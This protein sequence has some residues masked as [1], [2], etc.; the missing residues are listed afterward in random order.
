MRRLVLPL[1]GATICWLG[2]AALVQLNDGFGAGD[3]PSFAFWC[4]IFALYLVAVWW[5]GSSLLSRSRSAVRLLQA[6]L[7]GAGSGFLFTLIVALGLGPWIGAYSFPVGLLWL[8]TG[9]L[10]FLGATAVEGPSTSNPPR[11]PFLRLAAI[12]IPFIAFPIVLVGGD[13]YLWGR[14]V[15]SRYE[16]PPDFVGPVVVVYEVPGAPALARDDGGFRITVPNSG[17]VLTSN[18]PNP[19]WRSPDVV[20][21]EGDGFVPVATDWPHQNDTLQEVRAYWLGNRGRISL[22]GVPQPFMAYEAFAVS[23]PERDREVRRRSE[24]ML[25]SLWALYAR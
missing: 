17:I 16:L 1:L 9:L 24:S 7:L 4:A 8:L 23:P 10:T 21:E 20:Q 14:A 6:S 15:H 22:N 5:V 3:L 13:L 18:Q 25:D 12:L 2:A 19:G 11:R